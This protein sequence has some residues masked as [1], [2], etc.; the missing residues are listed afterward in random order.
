VAFESMA[1]LLGT[2]T[3]LSSECL[4]ASTSVVSQALLCIWTMLKKGSYTTN[5]VEHYLFL[6]SAQ[7]NGMLITLDIF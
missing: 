3:S 7:V 4:A 5:D 1:H 2:E 6:S